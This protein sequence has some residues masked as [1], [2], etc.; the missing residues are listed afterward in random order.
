MAEE[1]SESTMVSDDFVGLSKDEWLERLNWTLQY[2][3]EEL[4]E[5]DLKEATKFMRWAYEAFDAAYEA[6][7]EKFNAKDRKGSPGNSQTQD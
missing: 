2:H 4:L 3:F 6:K 7:W 1:S 5:A